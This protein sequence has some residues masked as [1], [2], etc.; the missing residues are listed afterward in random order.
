[1]KRLLRELL[2]YALASAIALAADVGL[3]AALTGPVGWDYRPAGVV[4]F[5]VG[6]TVAYALSVKFVFSA[7]RVRNRTAEFGC[8]VV[9]GLAGVVVNL[10][11][12]VFAVGTLGLKI[13][14]AKGMAA[15]CTFATN[16]I[17][18]RQ[19]LFRSRV[20]A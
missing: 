2:G 4:S 20:I 10:M 15:V 9:L 17:L 14:I 13:L 19:F 12:M 8:F 1:M 7:H 6:A 11:V 3:L 16:F 5:M 18:R